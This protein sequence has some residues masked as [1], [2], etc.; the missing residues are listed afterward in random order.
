MLLLEGC[1]S[2]AY[3]G[4]KLTPVSQGIQDLPICE[5]IVP[6]GHLLSSIYGLS[7]IFNRLHLVTFVGMGVSD[8]RPGPI[9]DNYYVSPLLRPSLVRSKHSLDEQP[10][11]LNQGEGRSEERMLYRRD[12]PHLL[13]L[14]TVLDYILECHR[15]TLGVC[16][17]QLICAVRQHLAI[18]TLP[19][20]FLRARKKYTISKADASSPT[21]HKAPR[22]ADAPEERT[23]CEN[24]SMS[25]LTVSSPRPLTQASKTTRATWLWSR[26][27]SRTRNGSWRTSDDCHA[28]LGCYFL[29]VAINITS[30]AS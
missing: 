17:V 19:L 24:P 3:L 23:V 27:R 15:N 10:S 14:S 7:W 1:C 25:L 5:S 28:D 2:E 29:C 6:V 26:D 12:K 30:D 4:D 13:R 11:M 18:D 9:C 16:I 20:N 8:Q 21:L 22:N